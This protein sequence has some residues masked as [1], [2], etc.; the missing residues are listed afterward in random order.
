MS[1]TLRLLG[2][3]LERRLLLL[4]AAVALP[5]M[6]VAALAVSDAYSTER[7]R[8]EERL[9]GR[10]RAIAVLV[11]REIG[12]VEALLRTASRSEALRSGDVRSF[13]TQAEAVAAEL[14]GAWVG[15]TARDG[16]RLLN[17]F[18]PDGA[19]PP[20]SQGSDTASRALSMGRTAVSG[21]IQDAR[22][23]EATPRMVVA[24]P[25][26]AMSDEAPSY[27]V[28][29]AVRA[30]ALEAVL[31]EL[32]LP[33]SWI[34][35]VL[36][37]EGVVVART[38]RPDH[39]V[40]LRA[41]PSVLKALAFGSPG[42]VVRDV[43]TFQNVLSTVAFAQ[44]PRTGY[45]AL[46]AVPDEVFA[47]PLRAAL[48]R[49]A[50]TGG[51]L[52]LAG[53]LLALAMARHL[54]RALSRLADGPRGTGSG[55]SGIHEVDA[56]ARRLEANQTERNRVARELQAARDEAIEILESIGDGFYALDAEW[57]VAYVNRRALQIFGKARGE[58]VGR[59]L[60]EVFPATAGS[61]VTPLLR[62]VVRLNEPRNFEADAPLQ[63]GWTAFSVYP[64]RDGGV[65][66][67]F[68]DVSA[69][70]VAE[71]AR[72]ESEERFR[73][74][75]EQ[76]AVGIAHVGVDGRWLRV[77]RRLCE[78]TGYSR[79]E[80]LRTAFQDITHPDDLDAD[81]TQV[82]DLLAGRIGSFRMQKR[83]FRKDGETVW[84]ALTASLANPQG[85]DASRF[86]IS[87]VED[88]TEL[89]RAEAALGASEARYR[90]IFDTAV[91]AIAV[92]DEAGTVQSVNRAVERVFGY[93]ANQIVGR[94]VATLMPGD[95]AA[96]HGAYV[97]RY[98]R[99]GERRIIGIGRRV[100]GLRE[101]GT[102]FPLDLSVAEWRG[103]DG[104]RL[105]TGIMRDAT[106]RERAEAA[107]RE[108][109]RRYRFLAEN[110]PQIVWTARPDGMLDYFNH[111]WTDVTGLPV[112]A[113]LGE[114]WA[115]VIHPD[116]LPDM[117]ADWRSSLS[118]GEPF[119]VEHRVRARDGSWRWFRTQAAAL[120]ARDGGIQMWIGTAADVQDEREALEEVRHL[121]G[122]LEQRVAE[123]T[124]QLADANA[125]LESFAYSVAHDLRA[126]LR[127]MRGFSQAL[128]EEHADALDETARDYAVRISR[129]A[130]RL[131]ELINDLLAYSRLARD[132]VRVERV[133]LDGLVAE[134]LRH[135]DSRSEQGLAAVEVGRP[136]PAVLGHRA[137]LAQVL[138]NLVGNAMK[139]VPPGARPRVHI[140]A[141][142]QGGAARIW[143]EDNGIGIRAEH[144]DKI[145]RVFERLHGQKAYPGTGI[146]LAIVKKGVERL[147]G[148]A[149]VE[150][151]PGRGSRFWFELPKAEVSH[152]SA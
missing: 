118:T 122:V 67:Y 12:R 70:R 25:V 124:T 33:A 7:A 145:F 117:A 49:T 24:V 39:T 64:R 79:D 148:A 44:V 46:V 18:W 76:A 2:G 60:D 14:G 110:N 127:G 74:T 69:R 93:E 147:G 101:D 91:D 120:R 149:G 151:E 96:R 150:S 87:V 50:A 132:E 86:F 15:V 61:P 55:L 125:E 83:Y 40:G 72:R 62:E 5:L 131:D 45:A 3:T 90:S 56:V 23:G 143:V 107:L 10:A 144:R 152:G 104:Q 58:L 29:A 95:H 80:L 65:S 77:N 9:Q 136:L 42:G 71:A 47:A 126:P 111:R 13:L 11:D 141:E 116:D 52:A 8:A 105:F 134:V 139:F 22:A 142:D 129:G 115:T 133:D 114:S 130:E 100:E 43:S 88:I 119:G 140:W 54:A 26:A 6:G 59:R 128:L 138:T 103:L 85:D 53:V 102:T 41:R 97:S 35:A 92:I 99:T 146:G 68:R 123:R 98:L 20:E 112:E 73:A 17:T 81:L 113:G 36:D 19:S 30:D 82:A 57:R 121:N 32:E 84:V 108:S 137:V 63:G 34:G 135:M 51:A 38:V 48:I 75:F 4:V 27:A 16:T 106:E 31:G 94:D 28:T 21:L 37:G 1:G 78:I 109:E 66:V 89:K